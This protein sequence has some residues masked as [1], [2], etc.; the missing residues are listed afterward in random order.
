[1]WVAPQNRNDAL[2]SN[3]LS[4]NFKILC[5]KLKE[6]FFCVCQKNI[7]R[8]NNQHFKLLFF[9]ID[10]HFITSNQIY[11]FGKLNLPL[12]NKLFLLWKETTNK[13]FK[14]GSYKKPFLQ[15]VWYWYNLL[16]W[17]FFIPSDSWKTLLFTKVYQ[18]H[19]IFYPPCCCF[20]FYFF[21]DSVLK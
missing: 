4:A 19:D 11:T 6:N 20:Y 17:M 7:V 10:L 21:E 14:S 8:E 16:R 15:F 1:M 5:C 9:I 3:K 13:P 12:T 2:I 18:Y